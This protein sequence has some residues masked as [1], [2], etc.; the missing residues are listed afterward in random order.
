MVC[1]VLR[2]PDKGDLSN[3]KVSIFL[4]GTIELGKAR[5]WQ[6]ELIQWFNTRDCADHILLINPR[7]AE[8]NADWPINDPEFPQ[9]KEQINWEL[10]HQDEADLVVYFLADKTMSPITLL[11]IGTFSDKKPIIC[12]EPDYLRRAN[13][14]LT[15][16]YA[17]WDYCEDWNEWLD[18]IERR[19][20]RQ[21][22]QKL[23][24]KPF[25]V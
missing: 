13:V 22:E 9:L 18:R 5:D 2:S 23:V 25:S 12:A 19:I 4:G 24:T 20:K 17:G 7:R 15:S 8:W 21:L 1:E 11:E 16:E 10:A 3:G 14:R 6:S